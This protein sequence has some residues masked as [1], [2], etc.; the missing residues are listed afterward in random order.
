MMMTEAETLKRKILLKCQYCELL[1]ME[2]Q[3]TY[4]EILHLILEERKLEKVDDL[5]QS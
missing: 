4:K 1:E 5:R 2:K 3:K